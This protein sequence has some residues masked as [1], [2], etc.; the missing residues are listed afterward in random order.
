MNNRSVA[1]ICYGHR[2][3][4]D[5]LEILARAA[6]MTRSAWI[7]DRIRE[8][9]RGT[10]G[11]NVSVSEVRRLMNLDATSPYRVRGS[12]GRRYRQHAKE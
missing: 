6:G 3:D 10:F 7:I 11:A 8:S 4:R 12:D 2:E 9:F 1:L 5:R